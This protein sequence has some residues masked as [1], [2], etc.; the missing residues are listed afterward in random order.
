MAT[1]LQEFLIKLGFQINQQGANQF[2]AT[3]QGTLRSIMAMTTGV[4]SLGSAMTKFASVIGISALGIEYSF[5]KI[6][7]RYEGLYY[8]SQR[9]GASVVGLRSV[10]YAAEQIGLTAEEAQGS[11]EG[12]MMAMRMN[13]G[14]IGLVKSFGVAVTDL[15]GKALDTKDIF[16]N[17]LQFWRKESA[18]GPAGF[19]IASRQA[20]LL[21]ISPEVLL[22]MTQN[23][24]QFND[25]MQRYQQRQ[26]ELGIATPQMAEDMKEWSQ[27]WKTLRQDVSDFVDILGARLLPELKTLDE[28]VEGLEMLLANPHKAMANLEGGLAEDPSV[29]GFKQLFTDPAGALRN[30]WSNLRGETPAGEA[31]TRWGNVFGRSMPNMSASKAQTDAVLKYFKDQ[32]W[33]DQQ[34]AG[35]V[36][37]LTR[38]S[39]LRTDASGDNGTAY[40]LGQW[41]ADRQRLFE[42]LTGHS[43]RSA[44]LQ[45][46]LAFTQ[47]ELTHTEA[48]AGARL[49]AART[50]DEAGRA[51]TG[52]ERPADMAG[53]AA[54]RGGWAEKLYSGNLSSGGGV[55]NSRHVN[56]QQKTDIHVTGG[57]A[58]PLATDVLAAQSRVNGDMVRNTIGAIQ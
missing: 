58:G 54:L 51:F 11:V 33:T 17:L 32:G 46:Q 19:A 28:T 3:A 1:T 13:P 15:N 35:I 49:R 10:G 24:D 56:V 5:L 7:Q 43:I 4:N 8:A 36:A 30:L 38:E 37:G 48:K 25:A 12:L 2:N 26:N 21:G 27:T 18:S 29:R 23:L 52:F 9:S 55:D 39:N 34:A 31:G 6:A 53:E 20:G 45:E 16:T 57:A 42:Q 47:W 50:P 14:T 22:Q 40:G 44:S 41:H